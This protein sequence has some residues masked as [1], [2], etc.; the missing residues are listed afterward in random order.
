[1]NEYLRKRDG[2]Q[3]EEWRDTR[4]RG[5]GGR[6]KR[7]GTREDQVYPIKNDTNVNFKLSVI[8]KA[9]TA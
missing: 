7:H 1:M 9:K 4:E 3:E 5:G 8:L 2:G 6:E